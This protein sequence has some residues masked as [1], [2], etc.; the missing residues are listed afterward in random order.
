MLHILT[1]G[2]MGDGKFSSSMEALRE[3]FGNDPNK[4]DSPSLAGGTRGGGA[5]TVQVPPDRGGR[6]N[7]D[8]GFISEVPEDLS[9]VGQATSNE[10][11]S[12]VPE[13]PPTPLSP[14]SQ[15]EEQVVEEIWDEARVSRKN[16]IKL[17]SFIAFLKIELDDEWYTYNVTDC[18]CLSSACLHVIDL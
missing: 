2:K 9:T 7:A 13:T 11:V 8:S 16:Y 12:E 17:H 6:S 18:P 10:N 4:R 5:L 1:A 14:E 3:K 15:P